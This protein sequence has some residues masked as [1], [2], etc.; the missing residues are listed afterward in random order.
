MFASAVAAVSFLI[1]FRASRVGVTGSASVLV[2]RGWLRT[3]TV[4][5]DDI[6]AVELVPYTGMLAGRD[7][8]RFFR[9]LR[10][11]RRR[12]RD[13]YVESLM[14]SPATVQ[15]IAIGIERWVLSREDDVPP[16]R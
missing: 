8:D 14:G 12:G 7:V 13:V 11:T 4:A 3:Q 15:A 6:T 2:V 10:I 9:T 1:A 16:H 5:R